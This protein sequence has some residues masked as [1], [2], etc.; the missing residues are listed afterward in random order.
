MSKLS[1]IQKSLTTSLIGGLAGGLETAAAFILGLVL[2]HHTLTWDFILGGA[3][4]TIVGAG[5]ALT[6]IIANPQWKERRT[7]LLSGGIISGFIAGLIFHIGI[8]LFGGI[9]L[10]SVSISLMAKILRL[11]GASKIILGGCAGGLIGVELGVLVQLGLS[12][13]LFDSTFAAIINT[14]IIIYFLNLG[15]LLSIGESTDNK[16]K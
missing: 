2:P 16:E 11:S 8:G 6:L 14:A 7:Q 5:V 1:V 9:I 15:I 13:Y 3:A 4:F 10:F 12:H